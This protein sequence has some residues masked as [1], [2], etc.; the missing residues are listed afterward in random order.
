MFHHRCYADVLH[1]VIYTCISGAWLY[2]ESIHDR[3]TFI[4]G[5]KFDSP[6]VQDSEFR[7]DIPDGISRNPGLK[8]S[9]K[10]SPSRLA[11]DQRRKDDSM[12][13]KKKLLNI[14]SG[15]TSHDGSGYT[16]QNGS[17]HTSEIGP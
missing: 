6:G 13:R 11:R 15:L 10:K 16:S 17:G 4:C 2:F 5:L 9:N 7:L 14:Y 12:G 1:N 3:F 8:L